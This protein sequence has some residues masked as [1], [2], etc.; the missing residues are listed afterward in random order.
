M[1]HADFVTIALSAIGILLVPA[2]ALLV[3]IAVKWTRTED[4]LGTLVTDVRELVDAKDKVHAE[5]LAQMRADRDATDKR[6]RFIE[7]WFMHGRRRRRW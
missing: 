1:T 6:L 7:E 5:M 3:R 2:L 4:R